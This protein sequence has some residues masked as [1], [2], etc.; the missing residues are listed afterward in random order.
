[1]DHF[2]PVSPTQVYQ[3]LKRVTLSYHTGHA[4]ENSER[5]GKNLFLIG[6]NVFDFQRMIVFRGSQARLIMSTLTNYSQIIQ[7]SFLHRMIRRA[8]HMQ[9]RNGASSNCRYKYFSQHPIPGHYRPNFICLLGTSMTAHATS[10][11]IDGRAT[12]YEGV[13]YE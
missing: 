9:S 5:F 11:T 6:D 10:P 7:F 4:C 3:K 2:A 12:M 13:L 1:M 8:A